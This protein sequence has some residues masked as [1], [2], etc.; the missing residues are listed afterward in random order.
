MFLPFSLILFFNGQNWP[1]NYSQAQYSH[2]SG[3]KMLRWDS[4][5]RSLSHLLRLPL[6]KSQFKNVMLDIFSACIGGMPL[7]YCYLITIL[8]PSGQFCHATNI[9]H[10]EGVNYWWFLSV[11]SIKEDW[12]SHHFVAWCFFSLWKCFFLIFAFWSTID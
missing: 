8:G 6:L 3:T 11:F 10:K 5:P 7:I 9:W 1:Y 2:F 4:S 12:K